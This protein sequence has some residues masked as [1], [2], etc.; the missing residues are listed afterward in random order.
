MQAYAAEHNIDDS[1][2]VFLS[3]DSETMKRFTS[4]IGFAY[5]PSPRGFDHLAQTTILDRDG[6]VYRQIY[7][8][9]FN[10]PSFVEPLK[11]LVF[12]HPAESRGLSVWIDKVRL[13][14]TIYDPN[15]GR[16]KFDYSVFVAAI[17]GL[18]SLGAM[19]VFIVLAWRGSR[20]RSSRA[21]A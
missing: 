1:N 15:S 9:I 13:F 6:R 7:G 19:A 11:E 21:G 3:A 12:G 4:E 2:W 17:T 8:D 14:C 16:Y 20:R 5:F 18:M 10:P